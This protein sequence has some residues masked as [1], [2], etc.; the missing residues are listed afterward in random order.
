MYI[1]YAVGRVAFLIFT[2]IIVTTHMAKA[3]KVG[4][5]TKSEVEWAKVN[6]LSNCF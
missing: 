3:R 2:K 1:V 5:R 4:K 6:I